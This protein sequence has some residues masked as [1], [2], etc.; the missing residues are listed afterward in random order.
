MI[1]PLKDVSNAKNT[2]MN[3]VLVTL[4]VSI[5]LI[6]TTVAILILQTVQVARNTLMSVSSVN[7]ITT[8]L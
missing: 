3:V 2:L 4:I 7:K 5:L 6:T 1:S 8:K